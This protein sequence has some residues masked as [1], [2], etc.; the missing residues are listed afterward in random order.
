MVCI[1]KTSI[2]T[3][4]PVGGGGV[5]ARG[6]GKCEYLEGNRNPVGAAKEIVWLE[7]ADQAHG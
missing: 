6:H 4:L 3:I 1:K 7:N 2:V 5:H